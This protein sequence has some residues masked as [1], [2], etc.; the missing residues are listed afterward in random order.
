MAPSRNTL[1]VQL[2]KKII[3]QH[4]DFHDKTTGSRNTLWVQLDKKWPTPIISK[5]I[6]A[7]RNTLWVQ[8]DKKTLKENA[9]AGVK[10][11]S[12]SQYSMSAIR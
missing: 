6:I 2:D 1:W 5:S 12:E 4:G 11:Y 3:L 7:S 8:L 10:E 9:G